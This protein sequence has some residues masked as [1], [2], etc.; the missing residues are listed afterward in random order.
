MPVTLSGDQQG[1]FRDHRSRGWFKFLLRLGT[2]AELISGTPCVSERPGRCGGPGHRQSPCTGPPRLPCP[3]SSPHPRC[4]LF[5]KDSLAL[6]GMSWVC[7]VGAPSGDSRGG[8][9][10]TSVS[11]PGLRNRA[12]CCL[13]LGDSEFVE[14]ARRASFSHPRVRSWQEARAPCEVG[15]DYCLSRCLSG[16]HLI[17]RNPWFGV[18]AQRWHAVRGRLRLW[19]QAEQV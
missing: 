3:S 16:N 11:A 8:S 19:E 6:S 13:H 10:I 14:A 5:L 17:W 12:R 4:C 15:S 9:C 1:P 2:T 7:R 18:C